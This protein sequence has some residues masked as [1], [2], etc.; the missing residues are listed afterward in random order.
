METESFS[1]SSKIAKS[2]DDDAGNSAEPSGTL[3]C[4]CKLKDDD[5]VVCALPSL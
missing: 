1:R 5:V 3:S 2:S 4:P